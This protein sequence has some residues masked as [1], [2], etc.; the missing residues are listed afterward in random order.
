[1]MSS[2]PRR[3]DYPE[4]ILVRFAKGVFER[5]DSVLKRREPRAAFIREAVNRE[6]ER[7][8]SGSQ[9]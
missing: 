4:H 8:K 1:M 2:K 3:T 5:I 6:I 7:R 9:Q